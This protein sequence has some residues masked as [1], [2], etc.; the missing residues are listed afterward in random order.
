[1]TSDLLVVL[2][3]LKPSFHYFLEFLKILNDRMSLILRFSF[4]TASSHLFFILI[5]TFIYFFNLDILRQG[6]TVA[7]ICKKLHMIKHKV[8]DLQKA[9][10]EGL[11]EANS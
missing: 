1:M 4:T 10:E 6:I 9:Y 2:T 8:E 11:K 5:N 7:N 3:S